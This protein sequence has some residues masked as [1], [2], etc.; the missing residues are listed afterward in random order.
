MNKKVFCVYIM[1]NQHNTTLYIGVTN[2]LYRRVIQHRSG[3]GSWFTKRYNI[4]KLVY[5]EIT[6]DIR[7]AILREKQIKAGS[8]K[9]KD[10][11]IES[12]N[13]DWNDLFEEL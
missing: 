7:S 10:I 5:F 12:D 6:G 3:K 8:R 9:S 2:N 13:P 4:Y 1:S 11:L